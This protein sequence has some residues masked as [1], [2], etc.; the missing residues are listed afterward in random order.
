MFAEV[1]IDPVRRVLYTADGYY[2]MCIKL[3]E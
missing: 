3:P 2:L 1:I